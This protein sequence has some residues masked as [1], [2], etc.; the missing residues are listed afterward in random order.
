MRPDLFIIELTVMEWNFPLQLRIFFFF[1][2][3]RDDPTMLRPQI[4]LNLLLTSSFTSDSQTK[5]LHILT[6]GLLP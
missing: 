4:P 6:L 3:L 5:E 1:F 2:N